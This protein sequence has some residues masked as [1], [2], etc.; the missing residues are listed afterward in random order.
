MATDFFDVTTEDLHP[1]EN[2]T[3]QHE[4]VV[5]FQCIDFFQNKTTGNLS[6]K[7]KVLS[8]E[9]TGKINTIFLSGNDNIAS[10]KVKANFLNTFWT[11]AELLGK[12]ASFSRLIARTFTAVCWISKPKEGTNKS[13][14]NWQRFQD[15]GAGQIEG[16]AAP[17]PAN[18]LSPPPVAYQP[19]PTGQMVAPPPATQY[20]AA[21]QQYSQPPVQQMAPP[22]QQPMIPQYPGQP[23]GTIW[24]GQQW[25]YA[26]GQ[27]PQTQPSQGPVGQPQGM[28]TF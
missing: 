22:P 5:L 2:P 10:K 7:C 27:G 20:G 18:Q 17:A 25:V 8:G 23:P 16:Q 11:E 19:L 1:Q 24:N 21:P 9:H 26:N 3:F 12:T 28:P 13:F 14:T 15:R 6:L 4:E